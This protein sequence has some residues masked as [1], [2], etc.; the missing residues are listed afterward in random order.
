MV[1]IILGMVALFNI[2]IMILAGSFI[3]RTRYMIHDIA[4]YTS[5]DEKYELLF[6]QVGDADW[7]FGHTHARLVLKDG[8]GTLEKHS[9]D[10]AND[11]A[12]AG[13]DQCR[14]TWKET[15]VEAVISGEEQD[16]DQYILYYK[17]NDD[18]FAEGDSVPEAGSGASDI[19]EVS[20]KNADEIINSCIDLYEKAA[21]ENTLTDP[22]TIREIVERFGQNGYPAVDSENQ[23][24]MTGS[25][26][27]ANFCEKV[28]NQEEADI[29]ILEVDYSGGFVQ[30]DLYTKDGNVDVVKSYYRYEN[31]NIQRKVTGSYLA[32]SWDYTKEGY[33]MFSGVW[34]TEESYVLTMSG[35]EE[36]TALRVQ[37]LDE[38]FRELGRKY[39]QPIGFERNNMFIVDWNEN[40][41]GQ[42]DF[43]DIY[44]ILYRIENGKDVPYAA[45]DDLSVSAVYRIPKEEFESVIMKYFNIDSETLRSKT[46]YDPADETYEYK[47]RGFEETEYPEYPYSEVTGS[48]ENGDGTVTL[49]AN[50]VFPHAGDSGVYSHEV[51]IRL[52]NDGGVQY[53]SNRIIPSGTD[54]EETWHIP[55]LTLEEWKAAVNMGSGETETYEAAADMI[56][57]E[58]VTDEASNAQASE[59][60]AY[61]VIP[62]AG[63]DLFTKEEKEQ[64]Q[65]MVLSAAESVGEIYKDIVI[66]DAP[67]YTSGVDGFTGEM[68]KAVV[69]QLGGK[70]LVSITENAD[71]QNHEKIEAFYSDYLKG[72]E[73]KVTVFDV[74]RDG[75]IGAVTFIY[76]KGK[77]QTYYAGVRWKKGGVPEI[78]GT[79]VS[80]VSEIKLTEKGYF[81]YA[82]E[83]NIEHASLR[84]Y[85]RIEPLSEECRELTRKYISGLSY[86]NYN[87]LVTN[88]DSSNAE[89]I[90]MPSMYE[91]IYR[92]YTGENL[93]AGKIPAEEYEKVMTTYLPVSAEQLREHCKYDEDSDSY[94]N[95]MVFSSPHPPFGEVVDYKKNKDGT[96]TLIVDGVWPDYD[97]DLAFRNTV[98]V[99]PFKDGTF[100]YLSNSIE[101]KELELPPVA[102]LKG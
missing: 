3:Y 75:L 72:R 76:R 68:G 17:E 87:M 12:N 40:D 73:S 100:R 8:S 37:P 2:L 22:E 34:Y 47:P 86:V 78:Q 1:H 91:D 16:D 19:P 93:K 21:E 66:R 51:V 97:S 63:N 46:V 13:P 71:M 64:L 15:Y 88:W 25:K 54:F 85:W 20:P 30:Y 14:V 29:T 9:F 70:G 94:E 89:D 24:N 81:I 6:Q 52:L 10:I 7:P 36:H 84:E 41:F 65:S 57:S 31:G 79:S 26:Q 74:H 45:D 49:T 53:V 82:Y 56:S 101:K 5:P 27:V 92:I 35:E 28:D 55:R 60:S 23:I 42:L 48:R 80:N 102:K 90:L 39:L 33:L 50:V 67:D 38:R 58:T 98:V 96:I 44:D 18:A 11:G 69:E 77:L 43:Y 32:E 4:S 99:R 62:Q 59:E 95:E 83:R 61:W